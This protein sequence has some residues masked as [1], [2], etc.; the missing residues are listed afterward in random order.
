M[1]RGGHFAAL[2]QPD[3]WLDDVRAFVQL[4]V[5]PN[6]KSQTAG[7]APSVEQEKSEL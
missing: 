2:E 4:H 6:V 1:P 5:L 3:L 7:D